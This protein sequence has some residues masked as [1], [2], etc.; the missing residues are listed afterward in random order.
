MENLDYPFPPAGAVAFPAELDLRAPIDWVPVPV[1]EDPEGPPPPPAVGP[2]LVTADM[3][4]ALADAIANAFTNLRR[5]FM[6]PIPQ[7]SGKKGEKPE[8]HCLKVEDWFEH[9][10]IADAQKVARFR[11]TLTGKA[12]QWYNGLG[13]GRL[14]VWEVVMEH[15]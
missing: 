5:D 9:F 2:H 6:Y 13:T 4:E 7:F 8:D 3:A 1:G 11:E 10:A 14:A 15:R 12:R